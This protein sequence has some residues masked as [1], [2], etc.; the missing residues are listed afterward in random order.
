MG[1]VISF[2]CR[3]C[4]FRYELHEGTGMWL[5]SRECQSRKLMRNGEWGE[6]WQKL[7][8]E[9]PEGTATLGRVMCHCKNCKKIYSEP[10]IVFWCF[11]LERFSNNKGKNK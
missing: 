5:F 3:D 9:N 6:E 10:R 2:T 7:L 1:S 4:I 11:H 8:E